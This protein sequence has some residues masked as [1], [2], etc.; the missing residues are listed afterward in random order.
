MHTTLKGTIRYDGTRFHGWQIQNNA[1]TVQEALE[2]A[3]SKIANQHIRV[4]GAGRTDAGV[5][6]LGQVFSCPWPRPLEPRLRHALSK[7]LGPDIQISAL[8]E[9]SADFNAR[10]SAKAKRYIY[11][12]DIGRAVDPFDARFAWHIPYQVDL[13][14]IRRLLPTLEG[15]HDFA[16]FQSAGSQFKTTV[17]TIHSIKLESGGLVTPCDADH[18]WR[19]VFHGNGFLYKMVRNITGTLIEIAR[20][21]YP[22]E[23]LATCLNSPG[24]FRGHCAPPQGLALAKVYYDEDM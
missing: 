1:M 2:K 23:F 11:A 4:Q 5:H 7:M 15:E 24:P 17:R 19:L 8:E 3:L 13:D 21:R 14:V 6:A 20:G 10:F 22:E 16:G 12:M 9:V 18:L